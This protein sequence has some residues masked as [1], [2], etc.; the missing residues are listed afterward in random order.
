MGTFSFQSTEANYTDSSYWNVK[1]GVAGG[2]VLN[3][4]ALLLLILAIVLRRSRIRPLVSHH[5]L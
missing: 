1:A 4:V 2:A 5:T 3:L